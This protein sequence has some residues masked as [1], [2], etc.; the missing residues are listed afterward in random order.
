MLIVFITTTASAQKQTFDIITY[1][2]PAGWKLAEQKTNVILYTKIEGKNWAQISIYKNTV[3]KGSI[4]TDF[5]SEWK[6]LAADVFQIKEMPKKNL[7]VN[8][9]NTSNNSSNTLNIQE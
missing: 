8:K 2:M 9:N 4:E 5:D 6:S 7:P 1:T 3:S